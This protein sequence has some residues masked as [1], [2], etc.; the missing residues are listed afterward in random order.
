MNSS[1]LHSIAKF[2]FCSV[3]ALLVS[4]AARA[5]S[6][7]QLITPRCSG[8]GQEIVVDVKIGP[9]APNVVGCQ[10][11]IDYDGS[12]LQ[13]LSADAGDAPFDLPI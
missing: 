11:A 9:N 10:S 5:E 3:A 7:V 6:S 4:H 2:A 12:V 8:L 1:T 13:F